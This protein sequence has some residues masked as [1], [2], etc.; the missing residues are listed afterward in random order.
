[1]LAHLLARL[2]S[3]GPPGIRRGSG[4]LAAGVITAAALIGPGTAF[5]TPP[6]PGHQVTICHRTNS[7]SNPYVVITVDYSGADGSLVH[8]S[9]NGDHT[10]H[11]GPVF[12]FD[13]QPPP[14]HNEDQ[15]G[16]IIPPYDWAGDEHHAPGSYPG[17][18]WTAQGQAI[19]NAGC[20]Q[21]TTTS[22]TTTATSTATSTTTS[23]TTTSQT[24]TS[25]TTTSQTTTSQ[26]TTSSAA[27]SG[28]QTTSGAS[29]TTVAATG[30]VSGVTGAPATPP[31]TSTAQSGDSRSGAISWALLLIALGLLG[32]GLGVPLPKRG[33]R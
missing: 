6:D 1:M 28:S 22:Q 32:L 13:N 21:P 3:T 30:G 16:D 26:T 18:N 5:A 2:P 15:W 11:L 19:W 9:G 8:D 29:S 14:P 24:T 20:G 4:W 33:L 7:D 25:Q 12:D 10:N 31:P 23:Q 17:L 27:T